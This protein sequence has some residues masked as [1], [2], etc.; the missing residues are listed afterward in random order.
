MYRQLA[1]LLMLPPEDPEELLL[2]ADMWNY[3]VGTVYDEGTLPVAEIKCNTEGSNSQLLAYH[4]SNA[5]CGPRSGLRQTIVTH[6]C[7]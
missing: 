3:T 1:K 2:L 5:A 6:W 7:V 4:Y